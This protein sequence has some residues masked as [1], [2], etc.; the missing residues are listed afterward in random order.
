[1]S[2][3]VTIGEP[4]TLELQGVVLND[5][6]CND[7]S[8]GAA[9]VE[10][11]GG[12]LPFSFLWNNSTADSIA[13]N[14]APGTQNLVVTDASGC[15]ANLSLDIAEPAA[16]SLQT[17]L[18]NATCFAI[19]DGTATVTAT[20]GTGTFLYQWDAAAGNQTAATAQNL[21]AGSYSVSVTD[22]NGCLETASVSIGEPAAL[23]TEINF[24]NPSCD[25]DANGNA[26]VTVSG[27]SPGYQYFWSNSGSTANVANLA[28]GTYFVTISDANSC[29]SID[30]A[31]LVT[32]PPIQIVLAASPV[33]CFGE[34]DG[35]IM[36][37]VSGGNAGNYGYSWSNGGGGPTISGVVAGNYCL[38]V[39]DAQSCS[40]TA[41]ADV[42][43]PTEIQLYTTTQNAGCDGATNGSIDLSVTGGASPYTYAWGSGQ[44]TQD[45][46]N[47][48]AGQYVV[49]VT[50]ANDCI[51][52]TTVNVSETEAIVLQIQPDD[53]TCKGGNDGSINL[54]ATGG[55]GIFTFTWTGPNGFISSLEDPA[56]LAAGDYFVQATDSDGCA[57]T[58]DITVT[59]PGTAVVASI[60][61]TNLI[62]F[63]ASTG[64]ATVSATGGSQP[65]TFSW[66]NSQSGATATNLN[67]AIFTVTVADQAGCTDTEQVEIQ[68]E[69]PLLVNLSQTAATCHDGTDGNAEITSITQGGTPVPFNSV[70]IQWSVPGQISPTIGGLSGGQ[71]YLVTVTNA[72]GCQVAAEISIENPPAVVANILSKTDVKCADGRDGSATAAGSGGASPFT[73]QW[74]SNANSQ[75]TATAIDLPAGNFSVTVTDS[76]GCT[77]T[78][79]V[80]LSEPPG[81][82][83]RFENQDITCFGEANGSSFAEGE[84]G[85]TP[86]LFLWSTGDATP[87]IEDQ[88]A[89]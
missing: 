73:F 51:A 32:P 36:A 40:A 15:T 79:S 13:A 24:N 66:S 67:A 10:V 34:N 56:N 14:L 87:K 74:S 29:T 63:G 8:D 64:T 21:P 48:P 18:E 4:E 71:S 5:V 37:Q 2:L 12:T 89:G 27:G 69:P 88:S 39:M 46:Q 60:A 81:L 77:A 68:Q 30:S 16:I 72:L 47:L 6:S 55:N 33:S 58:A 3:T 41:C 42:T 70:T 78:A 26:S 25:G 61:P 80:S 54:T 57:A 50:D 43:Q 62:C 23:F 52:S 38:T 7:G 65:Y 59:E 86:Y 11:S 83:L 45:L 75:T 84:G 76:K 49:N 31:T 53:V 85:V 1:N 22:L 9:T 28:A 44:T 17:S 20:G 19:N 35:Q 82:D